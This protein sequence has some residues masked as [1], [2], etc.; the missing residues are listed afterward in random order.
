MAIPLSKA[1]ELCT[2]SEYALVTASRTPKVNKLSP[3]Q[4]RGLAGRARK[5]LDK[6]QD[7]SRA[8]ARTGSPGERTRLKIELFRDT[9]GRFEDKAAARSA[10]GGSAGGVKRAGASKQVKAKGHRKA[11]A[12]VRE[13]LA[14]ATVAWD[15]RAKAGGSG[16]ARKPAVKKTKARPGTSAASAK[17]HRPPLKWADVLGGAK[18]P[19]S[20][21]KQRAARTRAKQS[22]IAESGVTTR[23][24]GHITAAGKRAQARRDHK[25]SQA[26]W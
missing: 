4:S 9:L 14:G 26:G 19:G 18:F 24:R 23:V 25:G 7:L 5:A 10:A 20:P 16:A 8:Q 21:D 15:G 11:R 13:E 17:K 3:E 22:R 12:A 2:S 1:K 6:W